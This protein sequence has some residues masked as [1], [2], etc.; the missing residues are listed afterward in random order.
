MI[1]KKGFDAYSGGIAIDSTD[2]LS[3]EMGPFADDLRE[4]QAVKMN[5]GKTYYVSIYDSSQNLTLID[6]A[7]LDQIVRSKIVWDSIDGRKAKILSQLNPG[8]GTTGVYIDSLWGSGEHQVRFNMYGTD[9][10]P[11]NEQ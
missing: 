5:D 2:T 3:F 4:Y 10:N 1:R 7:N 8:T 9:L 11:A 6:S